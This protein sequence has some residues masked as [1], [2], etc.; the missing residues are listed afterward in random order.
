MVPIPAAAMP[1]MSPVLSPE[2]VAE[3]VVG[4]PDG[5]DVDPPNVAYDVVV[6]VVVESA[7]VLTSTRVR[8]IS[9][10]NEMTDVR[11]NQ[12]VK[13]H[14]HV[15]RC[16]G[17]LHRVLAIRYRVVGINNLVILVIRVRRGFV[18][19]CGYLDTVQDKVDTR[20]RR[21]AGDVICEDEVDPQSTPCL[22]TIVSK[23]WC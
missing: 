17:N 13:Q 14:Q 8:M 18:C 6:V 23:S 15:F 3:D 2:D 10:R 19:E 20:E 9:R 11:I 21:C 7:S 16:W 12:I 5:I 4:V 22:M 1:I